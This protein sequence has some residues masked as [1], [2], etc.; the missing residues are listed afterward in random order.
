MDIKEIKELVEILENSTLST[1]EVVDKDG[2]SVLLEKSSAPAQVAVTAPVQPVVTPV[3]AAPAVEAVQTD[4]AS[5]TSS[6]M[7]TGHEGDPVDSPMVGVFY[8]KP[9]PDDEPYVEVGT[10]VKKGQ[11]LCIIEAMKLMNE[12]P[13]EK[14]GVVTEICAKDGDLIEFGQTLFYIK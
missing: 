11:T 8:R 7:P 5:Q 3:Q 9:S 12:I 4:A 10:Q 2:N 1:L 13:A 6:Q 14:D